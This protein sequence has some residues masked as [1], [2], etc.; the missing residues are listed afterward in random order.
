MTT[1]QLTGKRNRDQNNPGN[2][3]INET[4]HDKSSIVNC[5]VSPCLTLTTSQHV[6]LSFSV[7]QKVSCHAILSLQLDNPRRRHQDYKGT[8]RNADIKITKVQKGEHYHII[9]TY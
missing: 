6:L 7:L 5:I 3:L 8:I 2:H 1:L 9:L 4:N